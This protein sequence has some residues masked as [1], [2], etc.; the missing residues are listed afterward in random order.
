M[1]IN[2]YKNDYQA[3]TYLERIGIFDDASSVIWTRK[4]FTPGN[5]EIHIPNTVVNREML[6]DVEKQFVDI[7]VSIEGE[8]DADC[9]IHEN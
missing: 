3:G 8:K 4:Y 5:F 9:G 6:S 1:D 2:I 7:L